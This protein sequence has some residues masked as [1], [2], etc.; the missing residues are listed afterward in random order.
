V[1]CGYHDYLQPG[2]RGGGGEFV[3]SREPYCELR[4]MRFAQ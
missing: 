3:L 1:E 2:R 4:C